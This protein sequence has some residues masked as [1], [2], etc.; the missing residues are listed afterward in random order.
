MLDQYYGLM[1]WDSETGNP[2]EAKLLE[3]GLEWTL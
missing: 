2:T 3:L 1:S